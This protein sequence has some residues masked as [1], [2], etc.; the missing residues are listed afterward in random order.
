MARWHVDS[1]HARDG[2]MQRDLQLLQKALNAEASRLLVALDETKSM[3]KVL[4]QANN[5]NP[6]RTGQADY[7][8][9]SKTEAV[10]TTSASECRF[11]WTPWSEYESSSLACGPKC[12]RNSPD[13]STHLNSAN[14]ASKPPRPA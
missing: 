3:L 10:L 6:L 5:S 7:L 13:S 2:S 12:S 1:L 11:L 4:M 9:C 14:T 8:S